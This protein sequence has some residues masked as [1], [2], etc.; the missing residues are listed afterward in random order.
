M[1]G[2]R[3]CLLDSRV[4]RPEGAV[5][6]TEAMKSLFLTG[7]LALS[8]APASFGNESKA[9][10]SAADAADA[11]TAVT[12]A[13][14]VAPAA[15]MDPAALRSDSSYALGFRTGRD[16]GEQF[17][18]FGLQ[19]D[20][21]DGDSFVKAFFDGLKGGE[22]A[23][24]QA[25][26]QAA[27]EAFGKL[28]ESREKELAAANLEKGARFLAENGKLEGVVTTQSGLQYRILE[29]GGAK[30]YASIVGDKK[31]EK[32]FLVN[33][34]G[35]LIDGTEFDAS[36]PGQPVPMTLQVVP[37]FREA[38]TT[39]PVGAKWKLFLPAALG[40][41]GDRRS[42]EISPNSVL[43]FE[44]E[45][46]SIDDAPAEEPGA[47]PFPIPAGPGAEGGR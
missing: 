9:A 10:P 20:D 37:G 34:R 29:K 32:V 18:R 13:A 21:I 11:A 36:T 24:D 27:M 14:Q 22:P 43:I 19:A 42:A 40:Y 26:L 30:T 35:T 41:G 45:L 5:F 17:G 39:M 25:K 12:P 1:A 23:T 28:L 8:L 3:K 6:P 4:Q 44:L 7:A 46:V 47:F 31:T 15:P 16:F 2:M 38:L 33:Y